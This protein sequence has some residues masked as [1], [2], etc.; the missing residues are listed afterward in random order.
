MEDCRLLPGSGRRQGGIAHNPQLWAGVPFGLP[1][2]VVQ[3][4]I[5]GPAAAD[6][7]RLRSGDG[8]NL[9]LSVHCGRFP[10]H[11]AATAAAGVAVPTLASAG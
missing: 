10:I 1:A 3:F 2:V 7:A 5:E 8:P 9:A 6:W 4:P 11:Q